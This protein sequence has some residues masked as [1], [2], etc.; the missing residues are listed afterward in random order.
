MKTQKKAEHTPT[1]WK[2]L[3]P[4]GEGTFQIQSEKINE[5]GN[6]IVAEV[7]NRIEND[8]FNAKF[9]V[10]AVNSYK[11]NLHLINVLS[12]MV[13]TLSAGEKA[14]DVGYWVEEAEN[15]VKQ[16]EGK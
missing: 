12:N 15:A 6:F 5:Y 2:V 10:R 8:E 4:I 11:S 9:I 16:A 14:H 13:R 1:P 7:P 3:P